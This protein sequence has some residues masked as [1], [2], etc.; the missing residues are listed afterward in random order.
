MNDY[1]ITILG[2]CLLNFDE[3][4]EYLE[5]PTGW[6]MY[7][8]GIACWITALMAVTLILY[9]VVESMGFD[10]IWFGIVVVLVTEISLITPPV[11][12]NVFILSG[13]LKGV[14]TATIFKGVTPFW[15]ADI[16]RLS[17]ISLI[18]A[19]SLILPQWLYH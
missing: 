17:L 19:I 2:E 14:K 3:V 1:R 8:I 18:P 12:L 6:M 10:L 16:L 11:G 13:V 5:N 7:F 4:T 15:V 9:P